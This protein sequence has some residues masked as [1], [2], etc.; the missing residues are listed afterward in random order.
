MYFLCLCEKDSETQRVLLHED[1]LNGFSI[2]KKHLGLGLG[3]GVNF[4]KLKLLAYI[5]H[6]GKSWC[7][8][9]RNNLRKRVK[10]KKGFQEVEDYL[11]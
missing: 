9:V 10:K 4:V 1:D 6:G 2:V 7:S 11:L 8:Q 3:L 5:L